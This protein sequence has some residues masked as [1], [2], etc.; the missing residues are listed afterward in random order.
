MVDALQI[1]AHLSIAKGPEF[2]HNIVNKIGASCF[3]FFTRNPQGG[4]ARSIPESEAAV[5]RKVKTQGIAPFIG[6]LP[7][8]VNLGTP[9]EGLYEFATRVLTEDLRRC[10]AFGADFLV[11]H[12]GSHLGT[13]AEPAIERIAAAIKQAFDGFQGETRLLLETMA[14]HGT[15]VGHPREIGQIIEALGSPGYLG[16]C[17]DSCHLFAAGYDVRTLQGIDA[18]VSDLN[19]RAT[20]IR[21]AHLNDS[22]YGLDSHKDRHAKIGQGEIG[23]GGIRT[24]VTHQALADVPLIIETPVNDYLEYKDEIDAVR[25]AVAG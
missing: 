4:S 13:G 3:A 11:V 2:T 10:D 25:V 12:P 16:V 22:M 15:E 1:G 5:W 6:H 21:A 17:L 20:C 23:L 14:G 7:Y 8:T 24:F 9:K 19:C 18:A